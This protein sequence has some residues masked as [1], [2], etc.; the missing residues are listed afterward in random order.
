MNVEAYDFTKS[1]PLNPDLQQ[2]AARWL[3]RSC[4]LLAENWSQQMTLDVDPRFHGFHMVRAAEAINNLPPLVVAYQVTMGD[5]ETHSLF[6]IPRDAALTLVAGL[7]GQTPKDFS[8]DR[9]LTHAEKSMC[10]YLV[11]MIFAAIRD[12]WSGKEAVHLSV[13]QEERSLKGKWLRDPDMSV[14]MAQFA[15]EF[16]SDFG[17]QLCTW[18]VPQ[19]T[20][21]QAFESTDRARRLAQRPDEQAQLEVLVREMRAE[22]TVLLG[23]TQLDAAQLAKLCPGDVMLLD[24]RVREPLKVLIAGTEHFLVWPGKVGIRQAVRIESTVKE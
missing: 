10:K 15:F 3:R 22:L 9:E 16:G 19:E 7:L 5:Q 6:A 18:I 20:V 14:L 11:D 4:V 24:Q 13:R 23:R 17:E 12:S 21:A 8:A 1:A 2:R